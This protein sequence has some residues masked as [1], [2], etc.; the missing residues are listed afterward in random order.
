MKVFEGEAAFKKADEVVGNL[1]LT[2]TV[3]FGLVKPGHEICSVALASADAELVGWDVNGHDPR[4][5]SRL[6]VGLRWS[7]DVFSPGVLASVP[8]ADPLQKP[9]AHRVVGDSHG[10]V[11]D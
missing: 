3:S 2:L 5:S 6:P 11:E 9:V 4:R 8:E 7:P 1:D 10:I